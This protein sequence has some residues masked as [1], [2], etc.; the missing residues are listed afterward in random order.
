MWVSERENEKIKKMKEKIDREVANVQEN[1]SLLFLFSQQN[2]SLFYFIFFFFLIKVSFPHSI[3]MI[4]M[5]T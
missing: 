1:T 2:L 3:P 4:Q 5:S